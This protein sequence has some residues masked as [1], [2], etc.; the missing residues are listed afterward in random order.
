[1]PTELFARSPNK[2]RQHIFT[3]SLHSTPGL[4]KF[5]G[6]CRRRQSG[7]FS[8]GGRCA[9]KGRARLAPRAP[10]G[11]GAAR[12]GASSP[13]AA[14][15]CPGPPRP[16]PGVQPAAQ[17]HH[18]GDRGGG[19]REAGKEGS[20]EAGKEGRRAALR[21]RSVS[22]DTR[23]APPPACG[24]GCGSARKPQSVRLERSAG[25]DRQSSL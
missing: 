9:G 24:T 1:M 8:Q 3:P 15:G 4:E 2:H 25:V 14:R 6:L 16:V 11:P 23:P 13:A 17:Q 22:M 7:P 12:S 10:R 21:V 19:R 18:G 5:C 20:R